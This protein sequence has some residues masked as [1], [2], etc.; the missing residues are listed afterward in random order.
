MKKSTYALFIA[1]SVFVILSLVLIVVLSYCTVDSFTDFYDCFLIW[2]FFF[3]P[4]F[5]MGLCTTHV[6]WGL[7]NKRMKNRI[8]SWVIV[9]LSLVYC[10]YIPCAV[11]IFVEIGLVWFAFPAL[12]VILWLVN[13]ILTIRKKKTVL[14]SEDGGEH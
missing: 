14:E 9:A 5:I 11:Y 1:E 3:S 4:L 12:I 8:L 10:I 7:C 13:L 6:V 2:G